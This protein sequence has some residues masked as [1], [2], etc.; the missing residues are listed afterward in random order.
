MTTDLGLIHVTKANMLRNL[1]TGSKL[2]PFY[3]LH[4]AL[5]MQINCRCYSLYPG[6]QYHT[7]DP[8]NT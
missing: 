4:C 2:V 1:A 8:I 3:Y 7:N 6:N 5:E